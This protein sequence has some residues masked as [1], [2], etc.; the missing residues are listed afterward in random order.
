[1]IEGDYTNYTE[2]DI[3]EA[4]RVLT[5]WTIDE[6]FTNLDPDTG[7]AHRE[8]AHPHSGTGDAAV[9]VA[10]EHDPGVKTFTAKF[11][12]QSIQPAEVCRWLPD[13]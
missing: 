1:M 5:G 8:N 11:G 12:G 2:D 13:C 4:T 10:T 9:E 3:R 6:T 7:S